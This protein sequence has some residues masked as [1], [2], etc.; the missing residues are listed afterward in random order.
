MIGLDGHVEYCKRF[1]SSAYKQPWERGILAHEPLPC[2][3]PWIP[4]GPFPL[5]GQLQNVEP[6]VD[7]LSGT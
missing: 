3:L 1:R 5:H 4:K 2:I 6:D 7:D